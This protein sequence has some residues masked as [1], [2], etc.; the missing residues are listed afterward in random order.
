LT[1][2]GQALLRELTQGFD[3]IEAGVRTVADT[4]TGALDVSCLGALT[5]R[6]LIP[7]LGSFTA[8]RPGIEVRLSASDDPVDF[9]RHAYDVAIR[10]S[11]DPVPIDAD[12][13]TLFGD[14]VGP[15]LSPDLAGRLKLKSAKDLRRA[16]LLHSRSRRQA[17]L[18]WASAIG[19]AGATEAVSGGTEYERF[20]YMLEAATAGLGIGIAPWVLVIDDI[21]ARRLVAPFGFVDT[22]QFYY[23]ARRNQRNQ[24]AEFLCQWLRWEAEQTPPPPAQ[25]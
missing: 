12:I 17:W 4:A 9:S 5:M 23:V 19:W 6:W 15:V 21:K 3:R 22:G 7:R 24:K 16:T 25:I 2:E 1:E 8:I 10:V 20:F 13:T 11:S 14:A 18:T